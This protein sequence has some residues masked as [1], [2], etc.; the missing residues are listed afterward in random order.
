MTALNQELGRLSLAMFAGSLV[1]APT[2]FLSASQTTLLGRYPL[3]PVIVYE[4]VLY[5]YSLLAGILYIWSTCLRS[6]LVRFQSRKSTTALRMA[7][8]HLTEPLTLVATNFASRSH[9]HPLDL[10]VEDMN[11]A[12]LEIG[13]KD[14]DR[15]RPV[16][17]VHKRLCPKSGEIF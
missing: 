12:R 6:T 13:I 10:F 15:A 4:V 8:I 1:P 14:N 16:F 2:S 11:T 3:G 9:D 7:Q 17:G 5:S